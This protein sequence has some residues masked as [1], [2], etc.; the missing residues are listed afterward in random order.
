[1]TR[2]PPIQPLIEVFELDPPDAFQ[3]PNW[4]APLG[5][6]W[7]SPIRPSSEPEPTDD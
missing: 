6:Q 1:M 7:G 4:E 2:K 3:G 5:F